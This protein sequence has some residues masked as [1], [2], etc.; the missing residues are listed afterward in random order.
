MLAKYEPRIREI[1]PG[2]SINSIT[3]NGEGLINDVLIVNHDTVF[4]FAKNDHG[5]T[6]LQAEVQLLALIRP[7]VTLDIPNPFYVGHGVVAY[8]LLAG[9]TLSRDI[10]LSLS[11]QDKQTLADQLGDFLR[12]LHSIPMDETAPRT[13]AP[14]TPAHWVRIRQAVE[15]KVYPFLMAHQVEWSRSLFNSVLNEPGAFEYAPCLIHGDL[16][17]YHILFDQQS[18][19]VSGIIDFG[20]SGLGDP[21]MDLGNLIQTYGESFVSRLQVRYPEIEQLMKRARFYA[22]AVELQWALS[23]IV[24]GEQLWFLAHLGGARD[25]QE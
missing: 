15:E 1:C 2:L 4:R 17:T 18:R 22:Q 7:F 24:T 12:A 10:L 8:R 21:A 3:Y 11:P 19:R 5:V 16:G 14:V 9:E 20:V 23:G 6:A 25:V 13:P